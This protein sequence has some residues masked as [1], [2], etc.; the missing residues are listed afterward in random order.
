MMW[1]GGDG[2]GWIGGVLMMVLFWGGL[3]ALVVSLVRGLGS[4]PQDDGRKQNRPD[5]GQILEE[6]FVRGEI[7]EE[8]F[9]QRSR[10]LERRP[11]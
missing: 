3:V 5:A 11:R 8:E 10:V 6:R 7:S 9:E 4:R 1:G 2:W